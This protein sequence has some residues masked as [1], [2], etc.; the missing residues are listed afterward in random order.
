MTIHAPEM[1][2]KLLDVVVDEIGKHVS[3]D[4]AGVQVTSMA[5][6]ILRAIASAGFVISEETAQ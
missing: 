4:D 1:N 3:G 2:E 5:I 6:D